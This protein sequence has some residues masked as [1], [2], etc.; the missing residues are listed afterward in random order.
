MKKLRMFYWFLFVAL[1]QGKKFNLFSKWFGEL[2]GFKLKNNGGFVRQAMKHASL[3]KRD[4]SRLKLK[5]NKRVVS[6]QSTY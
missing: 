1:N 2:F 4:F 3:Y 6:N 5:V